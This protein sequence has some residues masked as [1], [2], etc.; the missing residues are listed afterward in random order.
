MVDPATVK[1]LDLHFIHHPI[2]L[3]SRICLDQIN[4]Q[5]NQV[6]LTSQKLLD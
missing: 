4:Q 1:G 2:D 5:T 3:N 6:R